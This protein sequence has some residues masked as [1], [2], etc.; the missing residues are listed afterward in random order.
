MILKHKKLFFT[1]AAQATG[2]TDART[3][4]RTDAVQNEGMREEVSY[5]DSSYL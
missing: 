3:D 5:R 1:V 2:V 4:A